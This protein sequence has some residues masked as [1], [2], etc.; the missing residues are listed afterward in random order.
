MMAS[1]SITP[2]PTPSP[3]SPIS[4]AIFDQSESKDSSYQ[5]SNDENLIAA[6]AQYTKTLPWINQQRQQSNV[7]RLS[8][9]T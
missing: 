1:S 3:A 5:S 9:L 8:V 7:R 6:A 2:P 4:T